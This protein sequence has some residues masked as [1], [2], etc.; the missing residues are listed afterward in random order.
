MKSINEASKL[1]GLSRRALQYYDEEGVSVPKR[2]EQ[3][4]RLY[5]RNALERIW[6]VM[7][8]KEMGLEIKEIRQLLTMPEHR[9]KERL[10]RQIEALQ[11]RM[12][13]LRVQMEFA[14]LIQSKG[15]LP[16]PE[17]SGGITYKSCI[18]ELKS[19]IRA[20]GGLYELQEKADGTHPN[21]L[22]TS[23]REAGSPD[24]VWE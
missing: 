5:D 23:G 22:H 7:I 15:M 10:T 24:Q 2:S 19:R 16:L 17:E 3:N 4:Y 11:S 9:K 14:V 12:A 20:E 18:E 21:H 13:A 8:Y 6:Q 1:T